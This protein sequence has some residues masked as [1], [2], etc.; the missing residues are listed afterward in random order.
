[1]EMSMLA[2][3]KYTKLTRLD[4]TE[5]LTLTLHWEVEQPFLIDSQLKREKEL[6]G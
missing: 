1:M 3:Y 5:T 4:Y 6:T 2:I